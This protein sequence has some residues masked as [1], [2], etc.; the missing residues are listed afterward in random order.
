[1]VD[2]NCSEDVVYIGGDINGIEAIKM[3]GFGCAP[4]NAMPQVK[5]VAD[6]VTKCKGGE[7]VIRE[8]VEL[9]MSQAGKE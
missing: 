6:Y 4:S 8:V 2:L 7:G 3:V 9:L 5:E 1:M